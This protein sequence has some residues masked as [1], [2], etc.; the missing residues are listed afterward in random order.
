MKQNQLSWCPIIQALQKDS[1]AP[2]PG[3]PTKATENK[4]D[5]NQNSITWSNLKRQLMTQLKHAA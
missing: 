2:E 3:D 4:A 5:C 1:A